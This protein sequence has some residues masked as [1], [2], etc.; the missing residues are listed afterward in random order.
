[1]N[2]RIKNEN[3]IVGRVGNLV[4]D[5]EI[6]KSMEERWLDTLRRKK[7]HVVENAL[8]AQAALN[9][10]NSTLYNTKSDA[11]SSVVR[12]GYSTRAR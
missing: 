4:F 5:S 1:M 11:S 3:Q 9:I 2:E 6:H 8:K 12:G 7:Y 10:E